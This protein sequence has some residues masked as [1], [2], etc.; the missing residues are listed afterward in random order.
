MVNLRLFVNFPLIFS[1]SSVFGKNG[2]LRFKY[3]RE[4]AVAIPR[5]GK[6]R[7]L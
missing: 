1:L 5:G 3:R 7:F 4:K 6:E 2:F